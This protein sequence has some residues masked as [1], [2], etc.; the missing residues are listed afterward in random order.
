MWK[1]SLQRE[2]SIKGTAL[3]RWP[4]ESLDGLTREI[5]LGKKSR[6]TQH[7]PPLYIRITNKNLVRI[8]ILKPWNLQV[9]TPQAEKQAENT[10]QGLSLT[11]LTCFVNC[12]P[13]DTSSQLS[14]ITLTPEPGSA[15]T[16][17]QPLVPPAEANTL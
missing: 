3:C 5:S 11:V 15:S 6:C 13:A 8:P 9:Q 1:E 17:P 2:V 14:E 4:W 10:A 7:P 16:H 12:S